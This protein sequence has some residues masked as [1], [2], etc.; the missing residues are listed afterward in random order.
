MFQNIN[1]NA[2]DLDSNENARESMKKLNSN[3]SLIMWQTHSTM[4]PV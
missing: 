3:M 4:K 1:E 2:I